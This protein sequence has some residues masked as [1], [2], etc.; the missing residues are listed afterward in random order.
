MQLEHAATMSSTKRSRQRPAEVQPASS[1]PASKRLKSSHVPAPSPSQSQTQPG[2][3]SGLGFL[4]DEDARVGRKLNAQLTNGISQSKSTR[5]DDSHAVVRPANAD[6][7]S[8]SDDGSSGEEDGVPTADPE[9]IELSSN[10]ESSDEDSD[11]EATAAPSKPLTNGNSTASRSQ[12]AL[13]RTEDTE[14][15]DT[16]ETTFGDLL[17]ARHPDPIDV[18][19]A[20]QTTNPNDRSLLPTAGAQSRTTVTPAS[21]GVVL[22][23]ALKTRDKDLLESCFRMT[24]HASIRATIQ[25]QQSQQVATLLE[26]IAERIHKR[27]GRTGKLM[28]WVQWSLV[29]HGGYLASQPELM[30]KLKSLGAV[31]RERANGLQPLLHLKGKLDLLSAQMEL[32]KGLQA[33]SRAANADDLDDEDNVLY[34]EGQGQDWSDSDEGED[35]GQIA[36]GRKGRALQMKDADDESSANEDDA[37][38]GHLANG[39]VLGMDDDSSVESTD[40]EEEG[41]GLLDMEAEERSDEEDDTSNDEADTDAPSDEDEEDSEG[42]ESDEPAVKQPKHSTLNRKR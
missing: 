16:A 24:D 41:P 39:T 17:Q 2:A 11:D 1:L 28:T 19:K 34:V 10:S 21:L 38:L 27:P 14:M 3:A 8:S 40:D 22:T 12:Q 33:A 13:V 15:I 42:D 26:V 23:Q 32:R 7:S 4:V 36:L 31:V 29:S 37:V 30:K 35:V 6:P 9:I 18:H 20:L 25:R 5:V